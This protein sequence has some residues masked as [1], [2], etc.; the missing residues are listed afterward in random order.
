ME[1]KKLDIANFRVNPLLVFGLTSYMASL[2]IYI[3]ANVVL[4]A[5]PAN[6][7]ALFIL[8]IVQAFGAASVISLG[9]GTVADITEPKVRASAMSIVLLGPQLGPVLGPLLSGAITGGAN[10]R[11]TFGFLGKCVQITASFGKDRLKSTRQPSP[12]PPYILS[13]RFA[14]RKLSVLS[15]AM[16][17]S[18]S[19]NPG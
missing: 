12:V 1:E 17:N 16:V 4:V 19:T 6:L 18:T 9:A 13:S 7:A 8:R 10:W 2:L 14:F 3:T 15:S 11:W 5:V